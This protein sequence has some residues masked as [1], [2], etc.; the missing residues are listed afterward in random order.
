[1]LSGEYK[2]ILDSK[3][4]ISLPSKLRK[5]LGSNVVINR[6]SDKCLNI[7]PIDKWEK[8]KQTVSSLPRSNSINRKF[9]RLFYSGAEE[10]DIDSAGRILISENLKD[11]ANLEENVTL[12]G[13]EDR[14]EVWNESTWNEYIKNVENEDHDSLIGDNI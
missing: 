12:V 6:G 10:V 9:S 14:V 13:V 2:H 8:V 4:R 3:R 1:M 11:Y 7:Y 5:D